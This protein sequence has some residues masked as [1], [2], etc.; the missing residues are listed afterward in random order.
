M[1]VTA[2]VLRV[3]FGNMREAWFE[4]L[5]AGIRTKPNDK[6]SSNHKDKETI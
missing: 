1:A 3:W 2:A 5:P 6:P 4:L